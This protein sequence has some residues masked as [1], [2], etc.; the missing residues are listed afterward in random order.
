MTKRYPQVPSL[1]KDLRH[2][3]DW[4]CVEWG[5][6]IPREDCDRIAASQQLDAAD[7]AKQVL[8]AEGLNPEYESAWAGKIKGR[9]V[10]QFG[11]EVSTKDYSDGQ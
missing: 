10:E 6:C 11:Q 1:E 3:L 8:L 9:F 4:L 5:F 7:F 2:L